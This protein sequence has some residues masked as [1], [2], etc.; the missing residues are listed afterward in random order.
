LVIAMGEF[1]RTPK[2]NTRGGRDHWPRVYSVM[3]CGGGLPRG[4]VY[5]SSDRIGESP[6]DHPTTPSDLVH[7]LLVRLGVRPDQTLLTPEGRP[8]RVNQHGRPIDA[9]L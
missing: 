2:V 7:T 9:L 1:G 3:L 5:G 4:L 8:I 6:M